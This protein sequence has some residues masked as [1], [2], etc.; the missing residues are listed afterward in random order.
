[1]SNYLIKLIESSNLEKSKADYMLAK[2]Q[3]F[4][5]IAEEWAEKSKTIKV[6][7]VMQTEDMEK[8]K[9]GRLLLKK[10]RVEIEKTRK[11][12]K[13]QSLREGQAIDKIAKTLIGMIE[14]TEDYLEQQEK[15]VEIQEAKR[16]EELK[17]L[18][19]EQLKPYEVHTELY[20][21][22][23]MSDAEFNDLLVIK[24]TAH[25]HRLQAEKD[26][27]EKEEAEKAEH[28]RIRV[29]NENLKKKQAKLIAENKAKGQQLADLKKAK[30]ES[31]KPEELNLQITQQLEQES[32]PSSDWIWECT[33]AAEVPREYLMLDQVKINTTV[34][35]EYL[36]LDQVKIN[37]AVRSGV[38]VIPGVRIYEKQQAVTR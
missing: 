6:T 30:E 8:A 33:N 19:T 23:L 17:A 38:R 31:K 27:I 9:E 28:E 3:D 24:K 25:E 32:E 10:K 2:F 4:S 12:L 14:P 7:S 29:E 13:E 35:R 11:D 37:T 18:R 20:R 21:L 22:D 36:M 34:P 26:R 1:M 16:K 5:A 15:Y